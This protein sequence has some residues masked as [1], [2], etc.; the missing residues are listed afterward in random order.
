VDCWAA[1]TK[2]D[3]GFGFVVSTFLFDH[4]WEV[5]NMLSTSLIFAVATA[6]LS[7]QTEAQ[8]LNTMTKGPGYIKYNTVTGY[9]LQDE[10]DTVASG[11]DYVCCSFRSR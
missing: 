2:A 1:G 4:S 3:G 7:G 10:P 8:Y 9:F 6:L 5:L 11:F